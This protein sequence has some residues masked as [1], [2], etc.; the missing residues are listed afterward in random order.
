MLWLLFVIGEGG[1]GLGGAGG[2]GEG[3]GWVGEGWGGR[4]VGEGWEEMEE[5]GGVGGWVGDGGVVL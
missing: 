1:V 5:G 3:E 4:G 2:V